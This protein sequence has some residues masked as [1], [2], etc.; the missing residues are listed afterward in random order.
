MNNHIEN[1]LGSLRNMNK[2]FLEKASCEGYFEFCSIQEHPDQVKISLQI[3]D[4][5]ASLDLD[6]IPEFMSWNMR[7]SDAENSILTE[8]NRL[9]F[10]D[11]IVKSQKILFLSIVDIIIGDEKSRIYRICNSLQSGRW[12][13]KRRYK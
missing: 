13:F 5:F 6:L 8:L 7:D 9:I 10:N 1:V 2:I 12:E 11:L 4:Q 3:T